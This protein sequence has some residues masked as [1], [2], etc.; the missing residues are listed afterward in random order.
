[1][2][3][4]AENVTPLN[5]SRNI[6]GDGGGNGD[7]TKHRL[8]ELERRMTT[9]EDKVDGLVQTC[10]RIETALTNV[11]SKNYVLTVLGITLG[12]LIVTLA[13]HAAIRAWVS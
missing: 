11:A 10:T 8:S 6:S 13:G 9:L 1:M 3:E 2:A 12:T 5:P 4:A 7:L